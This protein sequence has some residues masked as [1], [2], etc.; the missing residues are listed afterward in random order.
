[1][2]GSR[3]VAMFRAYEAEIRRLRTQLQYE[4]T[5]HAID[6]KAAEELLRRQTN[7]QFYHRGGDTFEVCVQFDARFLG[8]AQRNEMQF[9]GDFVG[10]LVEAEI[11]TCRFMQSARDNHRR[12]INERILRGRGG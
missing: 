8:G 4:Q 11:A 1:M 9:V 10:H 7:I 6:V 3:S 12:E 2:I 5:Q